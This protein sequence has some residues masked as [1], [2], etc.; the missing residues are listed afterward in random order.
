MPAGPAP[1]TTAEYFAPFLMPPFSEKHLVHTAPSCL[2]LAMPLIV[3]SKPRAARLPKGGEKGV[4]NNMMLFL[5]GHKRGGYTVTIRQW[6]SQF[7]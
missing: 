5:E 6:Q 3:S 7:P 1:T 2:D 4:I